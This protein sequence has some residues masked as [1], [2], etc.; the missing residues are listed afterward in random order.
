MTEDA[1]KPDLE[2]SIR[3]I[4]L[5]TGQTLIGDVSTEILFPFKNV[6]VEL[7]EPFIIH[8]AMI[9]H[10]TVPGKIVGDMILT[11]WMLESDEDRVCVDADKIVAMSKPTSRL[12]SLY[13]EAVLQSQIEEANQEEDIK[14]MNPTE[15]KSKFPFSGM[16]GQNRKPIDDSDSTDLSDWPGNRK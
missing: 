7:I 13:E 12:I 11:K 3:I 14:I 15:P 5:V 8:I 4:K 9:P 16:S 10:P 1:E 6:V 2:P